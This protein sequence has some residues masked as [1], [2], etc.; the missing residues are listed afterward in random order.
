MGSFALM[1]Q[2]CEQ[3]TGLTYVGSE[4]CKT[5]HSEKYN[6][7][8]ESGHSYK[9]NLIDQ[10]SPAAPVYPSFVTNFMALPTG[11]DSW[12]DIAG[13]IGGFGWKTRFVDTT[14]VIVGTASSI[15]NAAGGENQ[16]NFFP[17][18]DGKGTF[19]D[20]EKDTVDKEY[21][22]GCFKCHTTGAESAD[23][24]G[25][26]WIEEKLGLTSD[27]DLGYF[28]F[29]GVQ[30]EACHGKGSD[31]VASPS[32]EN[33]TNPSGEAIN[34]LCGT[35]HFRDAEHDVLASGDFIRHHEQ[36]DEFIHTEHYNQ[37][38][39]CSSCHDPHKR[40]IWHGDGVD[41]NNCRN[42]HPSVATASP[43]DSVD[44]ITCHMP[45]AAKSAKETGY[46]RGDVRS[47]SFAIS[48]DAAW[49]MI[50][51]EG[52]KTIMQVDTDGYTKIGLAY[53]CYQC[54]TNEFGDGGGG[55]ER[56][57]DELA[58]YAILVHSN[59]GNSM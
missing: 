53:A 50:V 15:I 19:S 18:Y 30:C 33:I 3:P 46:L 34:D 7:F 57:L 8:I 51:E 4:S 56:T 58:D 40:T 29:G 16:L 17:L 43:H 1:G 25:K 6:D 47:H 21:N 23:E 11:A 55:S 13:V 22:Y 20:Y 2:S 28:E 26:N 24:N 37:N 38:M 44:C 52:G 5:C 27:R 48:T 59:T 12:A 42:C 41:E 9:F 39:T 45:Y 54:H 32:K 31:H 35:C 10:T 36:Y 14:G 49:E